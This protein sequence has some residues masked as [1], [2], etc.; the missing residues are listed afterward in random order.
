MASLWPD[1]GST[2]SV[3][4]LEDTGNP[5]SRGG[6]ASAQSRHPDQGHRSL[7]PG[8]RENRTANECGSE[9]EVYGFLMG[10]EFPKSSHVQRSGVY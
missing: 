4:A 3:A 2:T 1:R 9:S 7:Q 6:V 5:D 10:F 8:L